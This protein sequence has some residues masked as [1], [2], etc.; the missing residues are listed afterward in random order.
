[1]RPY[2]IITDRSSEYRT[3]LERQM[4]MKA[5]VFP[6]FILCGVLVGAGL[7]A[8]AL[9]ANAGVQANASVNALPPA[10]AYSGGIDDVVKLAHSGVDES[11]VLSYVKNSPGPF[12]PSADE[13]IK[14]RDNGISPVVISSML[15][16][17]AELRE[18]AVAAA[19]AQAA[20]PYT[21]DQNY[22]QPAVA[23]DNTQSIATPP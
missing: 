2:G 10:P 16:R 1:M 19:P 4:V 22:Q 7:S 23:P 21:A 11:V 8:R 17:G 3:N 20:A 13:I 6:L 9:E 5:R 15:E 12:N 18:H 14:L